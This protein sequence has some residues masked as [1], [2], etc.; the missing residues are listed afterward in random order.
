MQLE[1]CMRRKVK[2]KDVPRLAQALRPI[3]TYAW[4]GRMS[5]PQTL[6]IIMIPYA[7]SVDLALTDRG[8]PR[9]SSM[10]SEYRGML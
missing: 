5:V 1:V 8:H 10:F 4:Q 7:R 6:N 3:A 2:N 9:K